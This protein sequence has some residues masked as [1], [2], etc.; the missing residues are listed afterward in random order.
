VETGTISRDGTTVIATVN[1]K[2]VHDKLTDATRNTL[3]E[4]AQQGRAD[5]SRPAD[6]SCGRADLAPGRLAFRRTAL[7]SAGRADFSPSGV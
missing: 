3:Q 5:F 1:Y 4:A 6:Y 7:I 2:V